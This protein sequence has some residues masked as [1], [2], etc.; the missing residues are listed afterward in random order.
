M[1]A[2]KPSS[3]PSTPAAETPEPA[4]L[5]R[6]K[7][8]P[9]VDLGQAVVEAFATNERLNQFL[10]EHLE[11]RAWRAAPPGEKGR[12]IAAIVAHVHNVRRMWLVVAAKELEPPAKIDRAKV[13]LKQ[14]QRALAKSAKAM[15]QLL[16]R[17]VATG[18]RVKDFRPDVVGFLAYAIAHESHHRGQ[19]ALLARLAGFP[20]AEE[21][22]YGLWDWNQRWKDCGFER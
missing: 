11:P 19:I 1:P 20:L 14:A 18:G 13:T 21:V 5:P 2:K 8:R 7:A 3:P 12:T 16:R 10:L 4:A 6:A 22:G 9:P 17:S 15:D